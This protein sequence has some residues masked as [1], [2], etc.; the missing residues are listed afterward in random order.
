MLCPNDRVEMHQTKIVGHYGEPIIVDQCEKCGGIWFDESELF[1]ARQGEAERIEMLDTGILR[2]PSAIEHPDLICPR[3]EAVMY[4][5]TDKYFP[6]DIV[7]ARCPSCYGI[8]LNRGTF[9]KY[10]EFRQGL[11]QAKK[12]PQDDKLKESLARL[13]ASHE[14]GGSSGTLKR[15]GE[16][17]STPIDSAHT[18]DV[19]DTTDVGG[20]AGLALSVLLTILRLVLRF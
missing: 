7:L 6:K 17:L 9:T 8:W 5:F 3:D 14:G 4:R 20:T 10:Q 18:P 19:G 16:F 2:T 15:L 1:R 13:V 12:S 11:M